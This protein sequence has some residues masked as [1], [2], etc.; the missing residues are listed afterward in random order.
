MSFCRANLSAVRF[1]LF[2]ISTANRLIPHGAT[3]IRCMSAGTTEKIVMLRWGVDA[4]AVVDAGGG[5]KAACRPGGM[6]TTSWGRMP[7]G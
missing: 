2:Q 7:T 3:V 4:R 5:L 6:P 1:G